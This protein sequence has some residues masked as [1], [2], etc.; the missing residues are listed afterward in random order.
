MTSYVKEIEA[1]VKE[2]HYQEFIG[3]Q[4]LHIE[5]G[6]LEAEV[7]LMPF[8]KRHDGIAHGG[9]ISYLAD[10]VMGFAAL[11]SLSLDKTVFT[12]EMK[13]SFLRPGHGSKL[14]AKGWVLKSGK[15]FHF[16]EAEVYG[17]K[18]GDSYLIAKASATMAISPKKNSVENVS[19]SD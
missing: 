11:T 9:L 2:S 5:P 12:A 13:V 1:F 19:F 4:I 8:F 15:Q 16:C 10:T 17:K 7:K 14:R 18:D 3:F 6:I